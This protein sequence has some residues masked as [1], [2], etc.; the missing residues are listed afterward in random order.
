[1]ETVHPPAG[2]YPDPSGTAGLRYWDGQ[3]WTE[4]RAGHHG[5]QAEEVTRLVGDARR[6]TLAL[7]VAV[8]LQAGATAL[9]ANQV[10]QSRRAV[11]EMQA[12]LD[13][14]PRELQGA[15]S[16]GTTGG[17]QSYRTTS[18]LY[19]IGSLGGL[20]TLVVG[21]LFLIWFHRAATV[22]RR[23]GRRARRSPGWAVGGWFI[24]IGN[25]FLP[26]Q[27]ARDL[28][29]PDDPDRRTAGRWWTAYLT[30]G[31]VAQPVVAI[32]GFQDSNV[33]VTMVAVGA[34]SFVLWL[35]AFFAAR[36]LV[37]AATASLRAEIG[38]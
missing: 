34:F 1:M 7:A 22:A 35:W 33:A 8:P 24:P 15:P 32:A 28:F 30:A 36:D 12:R 37:D 3:Q 23:I 9:Q 27:S 16:I 11:E 5:V 26:Y 21:I 17:Y 29:R 10:R 31:F 38:S 20:P 18:P 13:A 25:L 6:A 19:P 2:W 14:L 4:H